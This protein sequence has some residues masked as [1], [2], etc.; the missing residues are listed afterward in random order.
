[1][2]TFELPAVP[3][4]TSLEAARVQWSVFRRM[5]ATRRLEIALSLSDSLR[6]LVGAGVRSRHPDY[7]EEQVRHAVIR[8]SLGEDLFRKV[9]PDCDVQV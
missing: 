8:L 6:R 2:A 3:R 9:Y 7:S 4:D 1:M 5:S